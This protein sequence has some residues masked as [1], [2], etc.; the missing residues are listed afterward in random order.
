MT[1]VFAAGRRKP[2]GYRNALR[3]L[4]E[5]VKEAK[6]TVSQNER[7]SLHSL[8]HTYTSHLIVRPR[9]GDHVEAR[10]PR[11][12]ERDDARLRTTSARRPSGTPPS[13][14]APRS[15]YSEPDL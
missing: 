11:Q 5:A 13:S 2:K 8:R 10:R 12:S 9:P 7:L 4:A 14:P 15:V 1:P 6:I 3:A